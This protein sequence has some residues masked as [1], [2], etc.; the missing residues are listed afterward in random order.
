MDISRL[1]ETALNRVPVLD[2]PELD[3]IFEAD[4]AAREAVYQCVR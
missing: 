2:D 3:D 1:V 4:R